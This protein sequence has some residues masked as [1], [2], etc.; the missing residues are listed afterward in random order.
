[1]NSHEYV[2]LEALRG[3][4]ALI[5][6]D[7]TFFLSSMVEGLAAVAPGLEVHTAQD[8]LEALMLAER[9]R[10]DVVVT[11]IQMPRL[12]GF[13]LIAELAERGHD[14]SIVIM[15]AFDTPTVRERA[16]LPHVVECLEK[17]IDF[18]EL[19]RTLSQVLSTRRAR[20][21]SAHQ[22]HTNPHKQPH[23]ELR[24][25]DNTQQSLNSISEINGMLGAALVDYESGMTLGTVG[26][27]IDLEVASAGNMEVMRAKQRVMRELGIRG[28][29]EDILITL[30]NQYHLLRPV[31]ATLFLYVAISRKDGNLAMARR[32]LADAAKGLD[33][34]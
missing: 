23:K 14:M 32:K 19:L 33:I 34:N 29:I 24:T 2:N 18:A 4:S 3:R 25:M 1:M 17:P 30:E 26:T 11:D 15:T 31:G 22:P 9:H 12:D 7:E 13:S 10:I 27:G 8:G 16:K 28:G 5:V 21:A 20:V 6:D